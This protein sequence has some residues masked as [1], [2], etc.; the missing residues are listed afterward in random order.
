MKNRTNNN[1][2]VNLW[3]NKDFSKAEEQRKQVY[4]RYLGTIMRFMIK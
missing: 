2:S 4:Q 3:D 1:H